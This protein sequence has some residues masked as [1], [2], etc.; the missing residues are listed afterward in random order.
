MLED[1]DR[2]WIG[3]S[4]KQHALDVMRRR[5]LD[6]LQAGHVAEPGF[7]ALAVLRG[8]TRAGTGRET[9]HHRNRNLAAQHEAHLGGL[10]DDLLHGERGEIGKLELENGTQAGQRRTHGDAGAAQFGNRRVHDTVGTE[11]LDQ[12]AGDLE[13]A[14]IDADILAHQEDALILLHGDRHGFLDGLGIAQFTHCDVH[15]ATSV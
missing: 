13:G 12:I 15:H 7:Q 6:H 1:H 5:R 9:H 11:T 3:D 10:V 2:V 4:G 8:G 14:A